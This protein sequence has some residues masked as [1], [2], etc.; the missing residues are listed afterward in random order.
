MN[1]NAN[2]II[3]AHPDDESIYFAG[4]ILQNCD[5]P[6]HVICVTNGG[7]DGKSIQRAQDFTNACKLLNVDK[8]EIWDFP[9]IY[10]QRLDISELTKKL[11]LL[12]TPHQ[13][14]THSILGEYGHPHHQDVSFATHQTFPEKTYSIAHNIYPEIKVELSLG[15]YKIKEKILTEIYSSE[16]N[17][18]MH[19]IPLSFYEGFSQIHFDEVEHVY[20][21]LSGL[22]TLDEKRLKTYSQIKDHL[23][24]LA[25]SKNSRMF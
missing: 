16:L 14:F 20:Q 25:S 15:S 19:V 17:R 7:A 11:K 23:A 24:H 22:A 9:D 1:K 13:V 6:W 12:P 18:F 2:L 10:E 3:V 5:H 4:L 21:V 8:F